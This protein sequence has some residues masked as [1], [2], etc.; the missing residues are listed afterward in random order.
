[1]AAAPQQIRLLVTV[2][3]ATVCTGYGG[4]ARV[5]GLIIVEQTGSMDY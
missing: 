4:T 5:N 3:W 2:G 1:M